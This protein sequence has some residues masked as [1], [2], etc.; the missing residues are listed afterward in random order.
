MTTTSTRTTRRVRWLALLAG[1]TLATLSAAPTGAAPPPKPPQPGTI[2]TVAGG[3]GDHKQA[4][5]ASLAGLYQ[6]ALDP[7]GENLYL[8]Q[9]WG[10][11]RIRKLDLATGIITAAAGTGF[12][13]AQGRYPLGDGGPAPQAGLSLPGG[14]AVDGR[15]SLYIADQ[16]N[17]RIRKVDAPRGKKKDGTISTVAG[18][19]GPLVTDAGGYQWH[20]FDFCGD[21]GKATQACMNTPADVTVDQRGNLY[22]ADTVNQRVRRVDAETGV[23]TTVAGGNGPTGSAT[24]GRTWYQPAY[25]GDGGPATQACLARPIDVELDPAGNLYVADSGNHRIRRVDAATGIISTVVGNGTRGF[26]GDGGPA[27]QACLN[28]PNAIVLDPGGNLFIADTG[29]QRIRR[30]DADTGIISTVAG[31]GTAGDRRHGSEGEVLAVGDGGPATQAELVLPFGVAVD[32]TGTLYI[33]DGDNTRVRRV[34]ADTGVITTIAGNGHRSFSGDG[35]PALLAE[36]AG[37]ADVAVGPDGNLYI[38]DRLVNRIRRLDVT[39]GVISTVAGSHY[40]T[41]YGGDGGPATRARLAGPSGVAVD[42]RGNLY[43]ADTGNCL[44]RKV[45]VQADTITTVAGAVEGPVATEFEACGNDPDGLPATETALGQISDVAIGPDGALYLADRSNCLIR[46]VNPDD[47]RVRTVAGTISPTTTPLIPTRECGYSGD[48]GP[49]TR[50]KLGAVSGLTLDGAGNLYIADSGLSSSP[51]NNR[52]RRVDATTGTI[53]TV[54]GTGRLDC[55][56]NGF[57]SGDGGPATEADLNLP[58]KVAVDVAGNLF[59][60]DYGNLRVRRVDVATG[61]ITTVAGTGTWN[62][63]GDGGAATQACLSTPNGLAVDPAD[64]D[65]YIADFGG[66]NAPDRIRKITGIAAT[67]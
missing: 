47:G 16:D 50:A 17:H 49:A 34:D 5:T 29:N 32:R 7:D 39:A 12:R 59:I 9:G 66:G 26:C 62:Y 60:A 63:C 15:G 45:N 8:T 28:L 23:I 55:C 61:I 67:G 56:G 27:T 65:L 40:L 44:V 37:V 31:N 24:L 4:T 6:I 36:M 58:S 18:G 48:G 53:T 19:N 2:T 38:A 30:I 21:G 11:N 54:A 13:A 3:L 43:I 1:L 46:K 25:C 57:Y 42:D 52:I 14:I 64:G 33:A 51:R 10:G 22:I 41:G 35:G 20:D